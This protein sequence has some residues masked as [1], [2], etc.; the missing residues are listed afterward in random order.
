MKTL[1]FDLKE[2]TGNKVRQECQANSTDDGVARDD[3]WI[4]YASQPGH[5][6]CPTV[7]MGM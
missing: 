1:L 2:G 7:H 6:M 4:M 3:T 5:V